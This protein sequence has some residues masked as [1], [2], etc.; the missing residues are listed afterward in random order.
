MTQQQQQPLSLKKRFSASLHSDNIGQALALAEEIENQIELARMIA[1]ALKQVILD[2]GPSATFGQRTAFEDADQAL[3]DL[4]SS[5]SQIR[6]H[7]EDL[8]RINLLKQEK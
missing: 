1:Q 2:A 4:E 8:E 5:L 7:V 6:D 3:S